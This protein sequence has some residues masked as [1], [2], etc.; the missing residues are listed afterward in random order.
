MGASGFCGF[1]AS[2]PSYGVCIKKKKKSIQELFFDLFLICI[3]C[4]LQTACSA[5]Y[6]FNLSFLFMCSLSFHPTYLLYPFPMIMQVGFQLGCPFAC[7]T[8]TSLLT[9]YMNCQIKHCCFIH[10]YRPFHFLNFLTNLR[11]TDC[12]HF[13]LFHIRHPRTS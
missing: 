12:H 10:A 2:N 4:G 6:S 9:S 13:F 3:F 7:Y 5:H 11:L 8:G 1:P